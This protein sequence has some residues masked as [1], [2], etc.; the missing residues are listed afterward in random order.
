VLLEEARAAARAEGNRP[1]EIAWL[2]GLGTAVQY[3]GE[4]ERTVALFEEGLAL[5]DATG[6]REQEHMLLHHLGRCLV[7]MGRRDEAR[8]AF[9]KALAI[10][11]GLPVPRFADATRAAL[12]DVEKLQS[13]ALE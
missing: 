11:E 1:A 2:L 4:R 13:G 7:E 10:R 12:A 8:A 6:L 3:C 9:E 5:C